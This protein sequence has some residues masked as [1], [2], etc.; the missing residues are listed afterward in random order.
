MGGFYG[1][2][3]WRWRPNLTLNYG[4][5]WEMQGAPF[6]VNGITAFP[7]LANFFGPSVGLFQPGTLSGNNDP[8]N[9]VGQ[10]VAKA[11]LNN[12]GPN[13][14]FAWNPKGE[15]GF[16]GK[17]L[18]R[19]TVL[20]GGFGMVYYDEGTQMFAAGA[21]NNPGKLQS[22]Q[23]VPGQNGVPFG[24]TV[25]S[26]LPAFTAFPGAYATTFHQAD[27]TF[28]NTFQT[29][30][31][32]L[33]TPY[34][35]NWNFGIQREIVKDTVLEA[36]YVGNASHSGWRRI[37]YNEVNIFENGFLQEFKNAQNN[38]AINTANGF[39]NTFA[40]RG[41]PGEV[42]LPIFDAAFGARGTCTN[43]GPVL[44]NYSN[45]TFIND[46]LQGQAGDLAN[47]LAISSTFA[48]RMFGSNFSPCANRFGFNAPGPLPINFFFTNPFS[49]GNLLLTEDSGATNYNGLQVNLR[50]RHGNGFTYM[51]NYTWSHSFSNI[52]GDNANNDG[53]IKTI[54]NKAGDMAPSPF[55]LRHV[56]N[57]YSLY[58][59]PVGKNKLLNVSNRILDTFV[60]GWK[61]SGILT[62]ASGNVFRLGSGRSIV[63]TN[64]GGIMLAPGVTAAQVQQAF[65]ISQVPGSAT[66]KYFLPLSMIGPDGRANPAFFITPT[67]PGVFGNYLYLSGRN[68][69]NIDSSVSKTFSL[70]EKWKLNLWMSA[71]NLLNHPIFNPAGAGAT[72]SIQSTAFGQMTNGAANPARVM[73]F[74]ANV[75]F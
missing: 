34:T 52:W 24:L 8:V 11:H 58:D 64:D 42:P 59:L 48:C 40:N 17:L 50:G 25:Q 49:A 31:P 69:W 30:A 75:T 61:V 3:S 13:L 4:L 47:R 1:Q 74:R 32:N 10:H 36:R 45:G 5:R 23:I 44:G 57:F 43:C 41:L 18:N 62:V 19:S 39:S 16:F 68:N 6:N 29:M 9:L 38:L 37:N 65:N 20:R 2:D 71:L 73:Q 33:R 35:E 66:N 53:P 60:G 22:L 28:G 27:F 51:A 14:G 46:L 56:F 70:T 26:P 21:G 12:I 67:T 7:D 55:D 72:L 54:R 15:K 63:N